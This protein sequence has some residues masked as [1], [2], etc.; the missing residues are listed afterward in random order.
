M[1][2]HEELVFWVNA[3]VG[4]GVGP[5]QSLSPRALAFQTIIEIEAQDLFM[6]YPVELSEVR[7]SKLRENTAASRRC[8]D[9][10]DAFMAR[11]ASAAVMADLAMKALAKGWPKG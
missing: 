4:M 10:I 9:Y 3:A 11:Y 2:I 1:S 5:H 7:V 6:A 8:V